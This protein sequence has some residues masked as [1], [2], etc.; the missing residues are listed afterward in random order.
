MVKHNVDRRD[1]IYL[2]ENVSSISI[3]NHPKQ[4]KQKEKR[5]RFLF[6]LIL[7]CVTLSV[8]VLI[9]N[10]IGV[11]ALKMDVVERET[12]NT[13]KYILTECNLKYMYI[14]SIRGL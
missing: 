8:V 1:I 7:I 14:R 9:L 6:L 2:A 5:T 4:A 3:R 12:F 10:V 13:N 11:L